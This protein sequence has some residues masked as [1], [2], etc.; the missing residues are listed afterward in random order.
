MDS[1]HG[2]HVTNGW[3]MFIVL[4]EL[5]VFDGYQ[6]GNVR[7]AAEQ[8]FDMIVRMSSFEFQ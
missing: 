8:K 6:W 1:G 4:L 3:Q 7:L 2:E 5:N